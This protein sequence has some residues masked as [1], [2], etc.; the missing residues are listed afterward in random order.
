MS[1]NAI[2]ALTSAY[3][4]Y[5]IDYEHEEIKRRLAS[6]GIKSSGSKAV[7][8]TRLETAQ[9]EQEIE[10]AKK[11]SQ[12]AK[13]AEAEK[14]A[15]E[16]DGFINILR[17]LHVSVTGDTEKDYKNAVNMIKLLLRTETRESHIDRLDTLKQNLDKI[18]ANLGYATTSIPASEMKGATAVGELNKVMMVNTS[19]AN[20]QSQ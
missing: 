2:S 10:M 7:D 20:Q 13:H 15:E 9:K 14:K 16:T 11:T 6:L 19:T 17:E 1:V 18:M 8:K 5:A 4:V 3:T 12:A